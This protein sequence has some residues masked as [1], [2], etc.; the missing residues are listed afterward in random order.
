MAVDSYLYSRCCHLSSGWSPK[1]NVFSTL[2]ENVATHQ[3]NRRERPV[4][5]SGCVSNITC[6]VEW[7]HPPICH[8]D[9]SETE[10][11][12]LPKWQILSCVGNFCNLGGFLHSADAA[13]GM[14]CLS[15]GSVYQHRL[16]PQRFPERH[17]GR[18]L[19]FRWLVD[20]FIRTGCI[21]YVAWWCS[22]QRIKIY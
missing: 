5:R 20:S 15:G 10:W 8:P 12:D 7:L 22:A 4:C 11:R 1:A 19:R 3:R 9:R 16:F 21:R 6:A 17:A 18:S 13:V 14:T 2:I